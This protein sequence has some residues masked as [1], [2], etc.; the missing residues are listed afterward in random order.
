M[1]YSSMVL[2]IA[3]PLVASSSHLGRFIPPPIRRWLWR[4]D[5]TVERKLQSIDVGEN[6]NS[7][8]S[9]DFTILDVH[10]GLPGSQTHEE[11]SPVHDDVV[12]TTKSSD[13]ESAEVSE[14][15]SSVV[16][17][18]GNEA[19]ET[20]PEPSKNH[21]DEPISD[22]NDV[23]DERKVVP[24]ETY[25]SD[26]Y[27]NTYDYPPSP[28]HTIVSVES[29]KNESYQFSD[30]QQTLLAKA[31]TSTPPKSK[32]IPTLQSAHCVISISTSS[33]SFEVKHNAPLTCVETSKFAGTRNSS[34]RYG[35]FNGDSFIT[36]GN[37]EIEES[38]NIGTRKKRTRRHEKR[39]SGHLSCI[40]FCGW[41]FF[42]DSTTPNGY[43]GS[44][45]S[46]DSSSS[47]D[48]LE[49]GIKRD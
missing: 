3:L 6:T 4:K 16:N 32:Q 46:E 35:T 36:T 22:S 17:V 33:S 20:T 47:N 40:P 49:M 27:E 5:N 31:A 39:H 19:I 37:A 21:E 13:A 44:S 23:S 12:V 14:R 24:E 11:K 2:L 34:S 7:D 45:A 48:G 25:Y 28:S 42:G 41:H 8:L 1:K 43:D 38:S 30:S 9:D 26:A 29:K 10:G 18:D 15:N